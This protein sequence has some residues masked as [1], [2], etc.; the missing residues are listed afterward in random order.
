MEYEELSTSISSYFGDMGSS[1]FSR[2][3]H[4]VRIP[5]ALSLML[6]SLHVGHILT[7][8]GRIFLMV[9]FMKY[10]TF[11]FATFGI[12][13]I[14]ILWK[15]HN[16]E[17]TLGR[18]SVSEITSRKDSISNAASQNRTETAIQQSSSSLA[19]DESFVSLENQI[20]L[21][22]FLHSIMSSKAILWQLVPFVGK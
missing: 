17:E 22:H 10:I 9:V 20:T 14:D 5:N 15:S 11:I 19:N 8:V 13:R 18:V 4:F 21:I 16:M 1:V 6:V 7:D 12:W 2:Y 3:I